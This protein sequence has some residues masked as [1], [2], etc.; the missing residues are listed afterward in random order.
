M[1]SSILL[2]KF[3][4][5]TTKCAQTSN[6]FFISCVNEWCSHMTFD[7]KKII[8]SH[9]SKHY[10]ESLNNFRAIFDDCH[11]RSID[12]KRLF[13]GLRTQTPFRKSLLNPKDSWCGSKNFGMRSTYVLGIFYPILSDSFL[14][15][16][17]A[18]SWCGTEVFLILA[19]FFIRVVFP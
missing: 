1:R 12:L 15:N 10:E 3:L 6:W 11:Q 14:G 9:R 2:K 8:Q 4:I 17:L 7:I 5:W 18:Y 16:Y 13:S 19:D